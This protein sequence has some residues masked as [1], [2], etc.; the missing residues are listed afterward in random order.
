MAGQNLHIDTSVYKI[1]ENS[2][3][4]LTSI[5]TRDKQEL[6]KK[7]G[8]VLL[9]EN[10]EGL[11]NMQEKL[12]AENRQSLLII[13]QAMDAAGKDGAI[14]HVMRG[15]NPQGT[16]VTAF[17]APSQEEL[18]RDYMWRINRALPRRGEIG[19]FNR[20]HYEEVVVTQIHDL[21]RDQ[22]IPDHLIH[23]DIW[24]ERYEQISN[25][26]KYL[27]QQGY[28]ILKFFLHLSKE[29]Q[30]ERLL[31]R[32]HEEDKNWKF[33]SGDIKERQYWDEYQALYEKMI[34]YTAKD[35]APWYVIP[36]DRKWF[37]RATV[38]QVVLETLA[39]M[40]PQIPALA[41]EEKKNLSHW[42]KILEHEK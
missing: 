37:T 34:Q 1:V 28:T 2:N 9:K 21:V 18:D 32:I 4:T 17:K 38:S 7:A 12:Y 29:E 22:Q 31:D 33:S 27:T 10:R 3:F 6:D 26:E 24:Q 39:R 36:A 8:Q 40:N 19:I 15:L 23:Q 5:D 30:K 14:K 41:D 25:W 35:F 42:K 20:S 16:H 11:F 13:F